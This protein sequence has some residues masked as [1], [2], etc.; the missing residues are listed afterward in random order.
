MNEERLLKVLL[1]PHISEKGTTIAD[2]YRQVVF[3]VAS[4]ATKPEIRQAV[5]KMFDV[6]VDG[7]TVCNVKGK[8][9]R[10]GASTGRRSG[11]K[12]A[13]VTLAEGHDIDFVGA[14]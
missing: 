9:K 4:D 14:Q 3:K 2:K 10:F 13:Y 7:V 1:S 12:K 11:W 6:K 8:V 5:E